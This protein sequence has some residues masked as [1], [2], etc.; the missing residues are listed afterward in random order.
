MNIETYKEYTPTI[1]RLSLGLLFFIAGLTKFI[2]PSGIIGMV[3][4]MGFPSPLDIYFGFVVILSE[5]IFGLTMIIGY[6]VKLSV[7]PLII[8]TIVA[9]VGIHLPNLDQGAMIIVILLFHMVTIAA[10]SHI[11]LTGPGP[12]AIPTYLTEK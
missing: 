3:A 7:V 11:A 2:N 8:I 12:Y 9:A 4:S 5:L 10:L 6:N 1:L